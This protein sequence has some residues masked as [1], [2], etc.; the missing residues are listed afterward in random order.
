M[1]PSQIVKIVAVVLV[2]LFVV[3]FSGSLVEYLDAS[4]IM[5]IQ[6]LGGKLSC[7]TT[8]GPWWQGFGTVTKYKKRDQLWFLLPSE[9]Q[10]DDFSIPVQFNDGGRA[11]ISGSIAWEMPLKC[12]DIIDLHTRYR[13]HEAIEQQLLRTHIAKVVYLTGPTM[14]STESY[15][16]RKAEFLG[17][18]D[19]QVQHGIYRIVVEQVQEKDPLSGQMRTV[20]VTKFVKGTDGTFERQD[21]SP[22]AEFGVKTLNLSIV[23]IQY[24]KAVED[25]IQTQQQA[26]MQ[27]QTARANAQKAE[28]DA[29]TAEKNGQ[30]NA[31]KARWEQ[32]VLKAR[33]VTEAQ[34]EKEVAVLAAQRG[35]EVATLD[36]QTAEQ[37]KKANILRGE[38]EAQRK[39]LVMNADGALEPKLN[40]LVEIN[41][42]YANAIASYQGNWVPTVVTGGVNGTSTPGSGAMQMMEILGIKAARDLGVDLAVRGASRTRG[43]KE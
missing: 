39:S 18:V 25:Q 11:R 23:A 8:P 5:V 13:S 33:A 40:A 41:K 42:N 31:A 32:E 4:D 36:A 12:E 37:E 24:D 15:A 14:S 22:L 30:A 35:K 1:S 7:Y 3:V 27:V 16:A 29:I 38:G 2:G 17:F 28:Q 26:F 10:K 9:R 6:S 20:S 34:Q 21:R 19:D 43:G